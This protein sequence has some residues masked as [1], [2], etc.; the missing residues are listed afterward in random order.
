MR[1]RLAVV[2]FSIILG[3]YAFLYMATSRGDRCDER[4]LKAAE[5]AG[6]LRNGRP[7]IMSAFLC[8]DTIFCMGVNDTTTRNWNNL[9]DTTC[10]FLDASAFFGTTVFIRSVISGDTLVYKKCP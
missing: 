9:A 6:S 2:G 1:N 4:C 8:D 7:F 5:V 3:L 10:M